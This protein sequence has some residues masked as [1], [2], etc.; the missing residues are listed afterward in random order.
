MRKLSLILVIILIATSLGCA[1]TGIAFA[2]SETS[3]SNVLDDLHVDETFD[4]SAYPSKENDYSLQVIQLAESVDGELLVYVYQPGGNTKELRASSIT[5]ARSKDNTT[6][7]SFVNYLLTFLNSSGVFYKYKVTNFELLPDNVRYYNVASI[8]R[9]WDNALDGDPESDNKISEK[10][11]N[12]GKLWTA[13]S[14]NDNITYKLDE[15][16]V[17]TITDEYIGYVNYSDGTKMSFNKITTGTTS[18]HFVA[19]STDRQIDALLAVKLEFTTKEVTYKCCSNF[20]HSHFM[21]I[22]D[23]KEGSPVK[24]EPIELKSD[25]YA[26]NNDLGGI[27]FSDSHEWKRIMSSSEFLAYHNNDDSQVLTQGNL[28]VANKQWVL[29]F[30]ETPVQW[31]TDFGWANAFFPLAVLWSGENDYKYTEVS[32]VLLL[33]LTFQTEGQTYKLGAVANRQ[34][35]S[36][37]PVND[38]INALQ[39][40]LATIDNFFKKAGDFFAKYWWVILIVVGLIAIG[41]VAKFVK[42]VGTVVWWI[43][44]IIFYALTLP[45]W[46]VIWSVQAAKKKGG[47]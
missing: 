47:S 22:R 42:P 2:A 24:Q 38:T 46:I 7:L 1:Q 15:T 37:D 19:F 40:L 25:D 34:T 5:F 27:N 9:K 18:A 13:T 26:S 21:E 31:Q 4:E 43:L 11:Y 14:E 23:R 6:E 17:V 20:L 12:V 45:V 3:Y 41:I 28:D 29:S 39:R 32:D 35:G 8:L 36:K 33:S 16:E 30:Y 44:K 10:A